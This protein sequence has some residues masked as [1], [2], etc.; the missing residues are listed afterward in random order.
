M[1]KTKFQSIIFTAMM[2][3]CMVFLHDGLYHFTKQR[4]AGT[5]DVCFSDQRNVVGVYHS[6]LPYLFRDHRNL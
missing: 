1:P 4:N 5:S 6:V 3:F 2:V